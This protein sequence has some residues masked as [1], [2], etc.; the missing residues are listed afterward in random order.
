MSKSSWA[1]LG[2]VLNDFAKAWGINLNIKKIVKNLG[3]P[4][5]VSQL[6]QT[7]ATL[8][9]VANIIQKEYEIAYNDIMDVLSSI[10][11]IE[12]SDITVKAKRDEKQKQ[13]KKL[14]TINDAYNKK[15]GELSKAEE[16]LNSYEQSGDVTQASDA[17]GDL[18]NAQDIISKIEGGN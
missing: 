14:S 13:K 4:D 1:W 3:G 10:S 2:D 7:K 5:R 15:M 16:H 12:D 9:K 8:S 11:G 6:A 17:E 18:R